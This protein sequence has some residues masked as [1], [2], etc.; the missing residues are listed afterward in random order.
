M[1]AVH[2]EAMPLLHCAKGAHTHEVAGQG[3]PDQGLED[4]KFPLH[5][6][7]V[8]VF[9]LFDRKVCL[10]QY[11]FFARLLPCDLCRSGCEPVGFQVHWCTL[12][13]HFGNIIIGCMT[14]L[15]RARKMHALQAISLVLNPLDLSAGT[16]SALRAVSV[17][18]KMCLTCAADNVCASKV[19]RR[20]EDSWPTVT[21]S[22]LSDRRFLRDSSSGAVPGVVKAKANCA[23]LVIPWSLRRPSWSFVRPCS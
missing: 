6:A 18:A 1:H 3:A 4:L 11:Q 16:S 2:E 17:P 14:A 20:I 15:Q 22:G 10:V 12:F 8:F 21:W 13:Q 23:K 9:D 19:R 5:R 7:L